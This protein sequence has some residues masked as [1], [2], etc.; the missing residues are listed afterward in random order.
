MRRP[1][2]LHLLT[3]ELYWIGKDS[4]FE[5]LRF[6]F[7]ARRLKQPARRRYYHIHRRHPYDPSLPLAFK[8]ARLCKTSIEEID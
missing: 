7:Q 6:R 4:P 3:P 2:A 1:A 8:V 5:L